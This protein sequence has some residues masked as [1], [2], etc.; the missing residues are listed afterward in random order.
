MELNYETKF[1]QGLPILTNNFDKKNRELLLL[2]YVYSE[3]SAIEMDFAKGL[4]RLSSFKLDY[5]ESSTYGE[6][7]TAFFDLLKQESL[8]HMKKSENISKT[9][10]SN[11]D[12]L[13]LQYKKEF[14]CNVKAFN[15]NEERFFKSL[16]DLENLRI[17]FHSQVHQIE[18]DKFTEF[19]QKSSSTSSS[20]SSSSLKNFSE[21]QSKKITSAIQNSIHKV[22]ETKELYITNIA[23][24]NKAREYFIKRENEIFKAMQFNDTKLIELFKDTLKSMIEMN[25]FYYKDLSDLYSKCEDITKIDPIKDIEAFIY[26]N[27]T[28]GYEPF[29]IEFIS[30]SPLS[31]VFPVNISSM[32]VQEKEKF[33][34]CRLKVENMFKLDESEERADWPQI[35]YLAHL[36]FEGDLQ[37]NDKKTLL[38]LFAK[39]T[40]QRCYLNY[41]NQA[42]TKGHYFISEEAYKSIGELING[43][44]DNIALKDI[45]QI[46][47]GLVQYCIIISQTYGK[48]P[49]NFSDEMILVQQEII[50]NKIWRNKDI[51]RLLIKSAIYA[52]LNNNSSHIDYCQ[53][54]TPDK[55]DIFEKSAFSNILTYADTLKSFGFSLNNIMEILHPL[56]ELYKVDEKMVEEVSK[57]DDYEDEDGQS[58]KRATIKNM[59]NTMRNSMYCNDEHNKVIQVLDNNNKDNS[60]KTTNEIE[61]GDEKDEDFNPYSCPNTEIEEKR[62]DCINEDN[63]INQKEKEEKKE[64]TNDQKLN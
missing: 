35:E 8:I 4:D 46:N 28:K 18:R 47:Y 37:D 48:A 9:L 50:K 38:R 25:Q 54:I 63:P 31:Q 6:G 10:K 44:L 5:E 51:W 29:N 19:I 39:E 59:I 24:T 26:K 13:T 16:K 22:M 58:E 20:S 40:N 15:L 41:L 27:Q 57:R 30:Y 14:A 49:Q 55:N 17:K 60:T 1:W 43:I 62:D 2:S 7:I 21:E 53:G 23:N 36:S 45:N 61:Q 42:R 56:C 32:S 3:Y 52:Q 34:E 12:K 64:D 11:L 33:T